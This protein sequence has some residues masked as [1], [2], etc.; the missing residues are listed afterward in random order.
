MGEGF[1]AEIRAACEAADRLKVEHDRD[2]WLRARAG[3][4][5]RR[6]GSI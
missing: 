3:G 1:R 2:A 4:D 5:Q 6:P